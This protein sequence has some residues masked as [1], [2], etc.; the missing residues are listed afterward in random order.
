M[1]ELVK[2]IRAL[3]RTQRSAVRSYLSHRGLSFTYERSPR[4][5]I[6]SDRSTA[7]DI[8]RA[9]VGLTERR[10]SIRRFRKLKRRLATESRRT[11]KPD[12]AILVEWARM[13]CTGV[14]DLM[15]DA[16]LFGLRRKDDE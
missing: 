8:A 1:D 3:P 11:G 13:W 2:K 5:L 10:I 14:S 7:K 6:V 12:I 15:G 16:K 4:H 9:F